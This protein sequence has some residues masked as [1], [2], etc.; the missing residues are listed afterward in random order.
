M[1]SRLALKI[2][3][4]LVVMALAMGV[5]MTS[6]SADA[7]NSAASGANTQ[8]QASS[9]GGGMDGA[10]QCWGGPRSGAFN[11]GFGM[12]VSQLVTDNVIDQAT[13]DA[14]QAYIGQKQQDIKT[15]TQGMTQDQLK[16][17]FASQGATDIFADMVS[18][19]VITQAQADAIKA[20]MQGMM[21]N[22]RAGSGGGFG[23]KG[24]AA[25]TPSVSDWVTNGL[26][27]QATADKINAY[28]ASDDFKAAVQAQMQAQAPSADS[29]NPS[30]GS[31]N[32]KSGKA[33]TQRVKID[34]MG[35][36]VDNGYLTQAQADAI[37]AYQQQQMDNFKANMPAN[38]QGSGGFRGNRQGGAQTAPDTTPSG[39]ATA[40]DAGTSL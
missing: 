4:V 39:G 25:F 21:N 19:G 20:D 32:A 9:P 10:D 37:N 17:Y 8:N 14:I 15:A 35:I 23:G 7:T 27:D 36:L 11:F 29:S 3:A 38:G 12:D 40:S 1:K 22:Q 16:S 2:S 26:I 33:K 5:L 13:A 6:A 34:I 24:A 31:S 28:L 18:A 30:G